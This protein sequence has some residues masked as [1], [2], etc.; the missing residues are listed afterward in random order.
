MEPNANGMSNLE[1][2]T[3]E[4]RLMPESEEKSRDAAAILFMKSES[5]ADAVITPK[6][7]RRSPL[8]N[9]LIMKEPMRSV[10][11]ERR[12]PSARMNAE[13][14]MTTEERL[15]PENT[16]CEVRTPLSPSASINIKATISARRIF[17]KSRREAIKRNI[18]VTAMVD[19]SII[20]LVLH[21]NLKTST[22][23]QHTSSTQFLHRHII[24]RWENNINNLSFFICEDEFHIKNLLLEKKT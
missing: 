14:M 5:M 8:P 16:S 15:N 23:W 17:Q 4:R 20:V 13:N 1:D 3:F 9:N 10:N 12:S 11:P 19:I 6:I 24:T 7:N 2:E 21:K 18:N 22:T